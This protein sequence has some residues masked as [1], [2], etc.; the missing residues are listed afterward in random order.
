[1]KFTLPLAFLLAAVTPA[2]AAPAA[3]VP[4][5]LEVSPES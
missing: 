2:I 4:V 1:M 3:E 5:L